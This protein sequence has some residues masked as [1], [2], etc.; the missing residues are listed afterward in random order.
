M[1]KDL[2]KRPLL[3]SKIS[4]GNKRELRRNIQC[5]Q[6]A[7]PADQTQLKLAAGQ[8]SSFG[9]TFIVCITLRFLEGFA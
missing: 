3:K 7:L 5:A 9:H 1:G 2:L 4:K 8:N 6:N